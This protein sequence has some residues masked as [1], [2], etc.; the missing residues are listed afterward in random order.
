MTDES[1]AAP[2]WDGLESG[3]L[4]VQRCGECGEPFF[5]PSPVCPRCGAAD[6][7]WIETDGTGELH[8]FTRQHRTAPGVPEPV[9]LGLVALSAGP[10]LLARV[11][12][13]FEALS[14]GTPVRVVPWAYDEGVDRGRLA[15]RPFFR[16]EPAE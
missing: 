3:R 11:D 16:A 9:V 1:A 15:G 8:A 7:A 12:A 13:P 4:L 10:R 5:P 2:F 14:I 6:V